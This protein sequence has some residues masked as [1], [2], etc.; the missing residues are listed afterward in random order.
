MSSPN[1]G[2]PIPSVGITNSPEWA[3]Q[4]NQALALIDQH[5]HAS[6]NGVA[7]DPSGL[8]ISSDLSF[9]SN[10]AVNLRSSR[11]ASQISPLIG[12]LDL[13]CVYVSGVDLYYNDGNGN[14]IQ[15]TQ[16]GGIA[17]SPG[18][19]SN[20]TSPASAS[21][22]A[23]DST[24]VWQS[25]A[26]TAANMDGGS[27]LIRELVANANAVTLASPG[28]LAADY[29]ITLPA[30]LP[31][32]QKFVT[33]DN[34]GNMAASWAV[35]GVSLEIS[36][37]TLQIKDLGV[38]TAKLA[39][40]AV[41]TA[42]LDNLAVT[43]AKLDLLSVNTGNIIDQAVTYPK[44]VNNAYVQTS[45]SGSFTSSSVSPSATTITNFTVSSFDCQGRMVIVEMVPQAG[46]NLGSSLLCENSANAAVAPFGVIKLLVDGVVNRDVIFGQ[47]AQ[48]FAMRPTTTGVRFNLGVL[49]GIH[50]FQ[51]RA[52]VVSSPCTTVVT[53]MVMIVYLI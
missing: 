42:K 37:N 51:M 27:V 43:T 32:S 41:T 33:L 47:T 17:G 22:V 25:D 4:L 53:N 2:L 39:N 46:I 14:Q 21:Y 12:A 18:S 34:S 9:L 52:A 26:N 10:N 35:D 13:N 40:L 48:S 11:Y 1:M 8:S 15:I 44:M 50:T 31:S 36:S 49:S 3:E 19:I 29:T 24:F 5:N 16:G 38:S 23:A 20:L 45:S 30:T 6:G 28:S 7:I